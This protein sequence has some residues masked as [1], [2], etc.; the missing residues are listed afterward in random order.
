[1]GKCDVQSDNTIANGLFIVI[2]KLS[3]RKS[4]NNN[5]NK[6]I[7]RNG[8]ERR[9]KIGMTGGIG[10]IA[11]IGRIGRIGRTVRIGEGKE[12]TKQKR[13]RQEIGT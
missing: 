3:K 4:K 7:I 12:E 8:K 1:M 6:I 2:F 13:K 10:G 5:N 9:K 11:R